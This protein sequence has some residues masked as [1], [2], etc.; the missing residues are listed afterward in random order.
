MVDLERLDSVRLVEDLNGA[1][2]VVSDDVLSNDSETVFPLQVAL[3][4][5]LAERLFLAPNVLM[6]NSPSDMV[7]LQ[8]LGDVVASSRATGWTPGGS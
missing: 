6:V 2:T 8:V 1:G 4:Y 5:Q 7:Y 3:G